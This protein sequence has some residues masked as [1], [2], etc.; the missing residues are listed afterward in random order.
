MDYINFSCFKIDTNQGGARMVKQFE[1]KVVLVTGGSSGIGRATA[2]AFG[3]EG[4]RV[5]VASR[6]I[7][8]LEETVKA[9][10]GVGGEAGVI[11]ADM[12]EAAEVEAM[13]KKVVERYGRLDIAFNNAGIGGRAV[14][15]AEQ[16]VE[17]FDQI[18][19]TNLRGVFLCMKYEIPQMLKQGGG[20]IVNCGSAAGV[21]ATPSAG[22]PYCTSK[23]GLM[24]LTKTAA[25]EY[26]RQG[27][28]INLVGYGPILTEGLDQYFSVNPHAVEPVRQMVPAARVGKTEEAAA[29]VLWL[30]SE[31]SA[32][33]YGQALLV[34]GGITA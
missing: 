15:L 20:V 2:L 5:V 8:V 33:V 16:T 17:E 10:K 19:T 4:A 27:I 9:I 28:R 25:L 23:H 6:R 22:I 3:R 29:A 32:F 7:E 24:G 13:V 12:T 1:G 30:S 11:K 14:P 31:A 34:D 21:R 18:M 26:A